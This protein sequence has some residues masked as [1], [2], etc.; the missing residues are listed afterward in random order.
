MSS[1]L[2]IIAGR[3]D[4]PRMI[5]E[6][7]RSRDV[8][9]LVV[10]FPQD[11]QDW[12]SAHPHQEHLFEK[13]G[14]L[15]RALREAG[16]EEVVFAGRTSRPRLRPWLFDAGALKIVGQVRGL[17]RGG[18]DALLSGLGAIFEAEGFRLRGAQ[19]YLASL[20]VEEEGVLG[21]H[22]PT[23]LDR[24]D[25][26]RGAEILAALSPHDIGQAVVIAEGVCL[27]VEAIAGTDAL[28]TAIMGLPEELRGAR[29]SGVL[30]KLPKTGQDRR[31]DLP[32]IGV[33][34]IEAA[35]AAGLNGLAIETGGINLIDRE[36][37]IKAA[38][39]TGLFLWAMKSR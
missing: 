20:K 35:H 29:P 22:S 5:A 11:S 16:V 36:A 19:D 6:D 4:L 12:M 38:D 9:Y 3:D 10:S 7:C 26:A 8:P 1:K 13:P 28:L 37:V 30:I 24:Q 15:F 32:S 17:L 39:Q 2:A 25:A 18:D 31:V 34:T 33:A 14:R 23:V 21:Q 27:G